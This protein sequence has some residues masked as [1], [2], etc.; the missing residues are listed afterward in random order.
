MQAQEQ[1]DF[2][3][4]SNLESKGYRNSSFNALTIKRKRQ[5][6]DI[7]MDEERQK[8]IEWDQQNLSLRTRRHRDR[9]RRS[10]SIQSSI[11]SVASPQNMSINSE[12]IESINEHVEQN[13]DEPEDKSIES[14]VHEVALVVDVVDEIQVNTHQVNP[15][16]S[17][18]IVVPVTEAGQVQRQQECHI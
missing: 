11:A 15:T 17:N 3:S 13:E 9:S 2:Q 7:A 1:D 14:A 6:R 12:A 16:V 18:Y 4:W 8:E 5:F 10:S